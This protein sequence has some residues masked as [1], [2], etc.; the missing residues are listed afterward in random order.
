MPTKKQIDAKKFKL[1]TCAVLDPVEQP[2][3]LAVS[4]AVHVWRGSYSV[5]TSGGAIGTHNLVGVD[6]QYFPEDALVVSG[7]LVAEVACVSSGS[8]TISLGVNSP[9]DMLS[10]AAISR[11]TPSGAIVASS[12][13]VIS[14]ADVI[15]TVSFA[16]A[17]LSSGVIDAYLLYVLTE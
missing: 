10:A 9:G 2:G 3:T 17:G 14:S 13:N 5:A 15:P 7:Y 11:F 16:S 8:A 12:G 1:N 4:Q 6:D